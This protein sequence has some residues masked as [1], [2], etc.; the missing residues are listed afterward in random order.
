MIEEILKNR[1]RQVNDAMVAKDTKTLAELIT[2]NSILVHMTGYVQPVKEWLAQIE[3]EEMRYYAWQEDAIKAIHITD[4][5]ASLV[6][7]SR[8]KA[9]V[10]GAGPATW[11]LQIKMDFEKIDG[12]WKIIKQSASTY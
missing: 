2:P 5:T 11:R 9:R 1:Y 6:G 12:D 10:W 4:N 8:V 7:Q 3:S